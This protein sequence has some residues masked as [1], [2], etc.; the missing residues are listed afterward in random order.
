MHCLRT[1]FQQTLLIEDNSLAKHIHPCK[2]YS[3]RRIKPIEKE[4]RFSHFTETF[5]GGTGA[6]NIAPSVQEHQSSCESLREAAAEKHYLHHRCSPGLSSHWQPHKACPETDDSAT[7]ATQVAGCRPPGAEKLGPTKIS[8]RHHERG[9]RLKMG[10]EEWGNCK[11]NDGCG[12]S[13]G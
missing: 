13:E 9:E 10:E 2:C 3:Q 8:G 1:V 6:V 7:K 11:E 4:H 12:A 5:L